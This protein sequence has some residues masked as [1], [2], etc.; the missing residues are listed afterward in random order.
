MSK[1]KIMQMQMTMER[2]TK[3]KNT[4]SKSIE[5]LNIQEKLN[6]AIINSFTGPSHVFKSSMSKAEREEK[7][8]AMIGD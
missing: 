2:A 1:E 8:K 7:F 3:V 4:S 6:N 5:Q